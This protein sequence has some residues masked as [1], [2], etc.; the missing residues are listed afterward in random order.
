MKTHLLLKSTK[1]QPLFPVKPLNWLGGFTMIELLIVIVILA[2]LFSIGLRS[3][4]SSQQKSRDA[5]RKSD[6]QN[7]SRAL[8]LYY[9][10]KGA[11]PIY[12]GNTG[13]GGGQEWGEPF[14]DP[15]NP[16]TLYMNVLPTDSRGSYYYDSTDGTYFQLYARLENEQDPDLSTSDNEVMVY[17]GTNCTSGTCNYGISSTNTTPAVGHTL[18]LE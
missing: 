3:F 13:V 8:E 18:V 12:S 10:D 2:L 6:L 15:D 7:V 9:N 1:K 4:V 17:S 14:V 16:S 11:Y 5:G